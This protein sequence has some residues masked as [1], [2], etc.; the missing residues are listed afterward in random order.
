[1]MRLLIDTNRYTDL[2]RGEPESLRLTS[3]ADE[4]Y[5]PFITLAELHTGFRIGSRRT[6]NERRLNQFLSRRGRHPLR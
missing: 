4:L 1:M 6:D 5:L 2:I 3:E